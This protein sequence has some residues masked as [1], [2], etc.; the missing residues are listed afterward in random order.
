MRYVLKT[1]SDREDAIKLIRGTPLNQG[2]CVEIQPYD[3][4]RSKAQNR[5]A[6]AWL[7]IVDDDIGR[8]RDTSKYEIKEAMGLYKVIEVNGKFAMKYKTSAQFTKKEMSDFMISI[9]LLANECDILLPY[10][11]DWQ[12]INR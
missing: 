8:S 10:P 5:T 9:E 1:E 7:K 3:D 12:D 4:V 6:H 11:F 2:W